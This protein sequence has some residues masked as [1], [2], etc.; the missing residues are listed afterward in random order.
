MFYVCLCVEA[1]GFDFEG[2]FQHFVLVIIVVIDFLGD[3]LLVIE[4]QDA[5]GGE[6]RLYTCDGCGKSL[7]TQVYDSKQL[8]SFKLRQKLFFCETC[9]K[10]RPARLAKLRQLVTRSERIC[11][12]SNK[13]A[14]GLH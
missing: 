10:V 11:K 12:C 6:P 4:N 14:P 5:R 3:P 7:G 9:V 2:V 8:R 1:H 13:L